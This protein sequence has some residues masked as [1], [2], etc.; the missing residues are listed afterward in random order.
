MTT[1][2]P[3]DP[4]LRRAVA[5]LL[6]KLLPALYRVKDLGPSVPQENP[7]LAPGDPANVRA[8][9]LR[10]LH[11][12][13]DDTL[14]P[15]SPT[16]PP[17]TADLYRLL[18]VL[19]APLAVAR[20]SV[21]ELH[22]DLFL[23][24]CAD[25]TLPLLA[26]QVGVTLVLRDPDDDRADLRGAI[27]WRR[28]KG[29]RSALEGM[30]TALLRQQTVTHEGWQRLLLS[31]R[32]NLLRPERGAC[33]VRAP[34]LAD[35]CAGPYDAA[36]HALD[37]RRPAAR[38]GRYHP[39]HAV[40]WT[41]ATRP[42][43]VR[44]G[45]PGAGPAL[46]SP[47]D[48]DRRF[49]FHPAGAE[50]PLRVRADSAAGQAP[51]DR[52]PASLF[53]ADPGRYFDAGDSRARFAVRILGLTAAVTASP[54]VDRAPSVRPASASLSDH[55]AGVTLLRRSEGTWRR[56][57]EVRLCRVPL[58]A[59]SGTALDTP[60][61]SSREDL[62]GVV[63]DA[64]TA[65]SLAGA[66]PS[67]TGDAVAMI[68]LSPEGGGV[69]YFPGAV[70]EVAGLAPDAR[71]ASEDPSLARE[72][73]LRGALLVEVPATWV[74]SERW[75]YL[76]DDGA[77]HD[78]QT[79]NDLASPGHAVD[80]PVLRAGA[81]VTLQHRLRAIGPGPVW[82][83]APPESSFDPLVNLPP[84]LGQGPV[85][86][87]A[88]PPLDAAGAPSM[89]TV[90]LVFAR[91]APGGPVDP[92][93]RLSWPGGSTP[94]TTALLEL[95]AANGDVLPTASEA[96]ARW[97]AI[98]SGGSWAQL[99]LRLECATP[100][101]RLPPCEVAFTDA[102]G[103]AT[104]IHVPE[105][106]AESRPSGDPWPTAELAVSDAFAVMRDGSTHTG[107]GDAVARCAFGRVIPLQGAATLRR[108]QVRGRRLCPWRNETGSD[109]LD[110][111]P[112]GWL[113]IDPAHGL[114]ALSPEDA[115]PSY[116]PNVAW[117]TPTPP[118]LP[119][120]SV[121]VDWQD[122]FT[123]HVGARP[124]A[125]AALLD[126]RPPEPTR[127]VSLT[128]RF[129]AD[130]PPHRR[131]LPRYASLGEAF[132]AIADGP[133]SPAEVVEIDDSAT[134][135]DGTL[136][137]P[138]GVTSLTVQAAEFERP[139]IRVPVVSHAGASYEDLTL[140]GLAFDAENV[141][142]APARRVTVQLCSSLRGQ[143]RWLFATL[144]DGSTEIRISRCDLA[145]VV[146]PFEGTLRLDRTV[147]HADVHVAIEALASRVELD[148]CTV[149]NG[150][151]AMDPRCVRARVLE[152]S[153]VLFTH[154]VEVAD[155]F[156]GC[157]RYSRVEPGGVLPRRFR[158][159][160]ARP[161][162]ASKDR[163]DPAHLRLTQGASVA[164]L[165]GAEDGGEIGAFHDAG[166]ARRAEGVLRRLIEFTPAGMVTGVIRQD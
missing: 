81:A 144:T 133:R 121:T 100:D 5:R 45:T 152:A 67:G 14:P 6:Y 131:A 135:T 77:L 150:D 120:P 80:V 25:G 161:E 147:V 35:T 26:A 61:V 108:R 143:N 111:T 82:P 64:A 94:A 122:G 91:K 34:T 164:L 85:V 105:L 126:A 11:E 134:Y 74:W 39:R 41:H 103:E 49:T 31:Q 59:S 109:R 132:Q 145:G 96:L 3:Y 136:T 62:G 95:L 63:I 48:A 89:E 107:V 58:V 68:R 69:A 29:T 99:Q 110:P 24:R 60:S 16:L 148:R 159:T 113:D 153:E 38:E 162:F 40:H 157:V 17:G 13:A 114:F 117:P 32:L 76:A 46:F 112:S 118:A 155:R 163:T 116:P 138:A 160:E 72:G 93:L 90:S 44:R 146:V 83:P 166:L 123:D 104:L 130:E 10:D 142:V 8:R 101:T 88:A 18:H 20:Q 165:R 28:R 52:V 115:V 78:A 137:W 149:A 47:P 140:S 75:F 65:A 12:L 125:R 102:S 98:A 55:Q 30:A 7:G 51:T 139:V 42:F 92:F 37:G 106:H 21:D 54:R 71:R 158:V 43:P 70:L 119:A 124:D 53:A 19:A 141:D 50:L 1:T 73:F 84:P 15:G 4:H 154:Q 66:T 27:A 151:D 128:G 87:H 2:Y 56:A 36:A 127:V 79:H 22:A 9:F 156:S 86:V 129:R 57:V 97:R 33:D 23:D